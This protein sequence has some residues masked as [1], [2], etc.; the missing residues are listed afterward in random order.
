[1]ETQKLSKKILINFNRN[2]KVF[3]IINF[4]GEVTDGID[5]ILD[6]FTQY[7]GNL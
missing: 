5:K 1:M 7:Y 2:K 6:S 4:N 3:A